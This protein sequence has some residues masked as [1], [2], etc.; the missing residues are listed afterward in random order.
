MQYSPLQVEFPS[1][2]GLI[3]PTT[4]TSAI[5]FFLM[6]ANSSFD[7]GMVPKLGH[8]FCGRNLFELLHRYVIEVMIRSGGG[9]P[10][11][12]QWKIGCHSVTEDELCLRSGENDAR[13]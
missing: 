9:L 12:L 10:N 3:Y 4:H 7:E 11:N 1:L 13:K 2:V 5:V 8:P 6:L